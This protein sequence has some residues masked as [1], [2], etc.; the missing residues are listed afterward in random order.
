MQFM[1]THSSS[2]IVTWSALSWCFVTLSVVWVATST[3]EYGA[4]FQNWSQKH[5]QYAHIKLPHKM[6]S[7]H[8]FAKDSQ[9]I[10][11]ASKSKVLTSAHHKDDL[12]TPPQA[13]KRSLG[14]TWKYSITMV[15]KIHHLVMSCSDQPARGVLFVHVFLYRCFISTGMQTDK[16]KW[17]L[18]HN[19]SVNTQSYQV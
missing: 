1:K 16:K 18:Y 17:I 10:R 4:T 11:K 7:N 19:A 9:C 8:W 5:L 15:I 2:K 13:P 3:A 12:F 14:L 6:H